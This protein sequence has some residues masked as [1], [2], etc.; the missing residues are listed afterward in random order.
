MTDVSIEDVLAL[1]SE[2]RY[3]FFL[4]LVAETRDIWILVSVDQH[5]LKIHLEEDDLEYLPVWPSTE[6]AQH[7]CDGL[8]DKLKPMSITVP[9]FFSKW[10]SGLEGDE[11]KVGTIPKE[12]ADVWV[13]EPS[14][15]KIDLQEMFARESGL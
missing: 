2:E 5:F 1:D 8:Q 7:Y 9:T 6:L 4:S 11:I 3:E 15:L 12:G 14:E 13:V 10:I